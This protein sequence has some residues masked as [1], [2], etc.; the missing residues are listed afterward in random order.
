V[1]DQGRST[2]SLRQNVPPVRQ[3][4]HENQRNEEDQAWRTVIGNTC[5]ANRDVKRN[6]LSAV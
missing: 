2:A 4:Q 3:H 1:S 6:A 5:P